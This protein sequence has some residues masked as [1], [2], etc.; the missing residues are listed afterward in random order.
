MVSTM[1][2]M[3][4]LS[5]A[6][7]ASS[8]SLDVDLCAKGESFWC[9]SLA[10]AEACSAVDHCKETIWR[11]QKL[12]KD[13]SDVCLFCKAV[14]SDA[15]KMSADGKTQDEVI[16]FLSAANDLLPD[17]DK[18]SQNK[19]TIKGKSIPKILDSEIEPQVV[20][21]LLDVCKGLQFIEDLHNLE[22]SPE[23]TPEQSIDDADNVLQ[24]TTCVDCTN[25][26][27]GLKKLITGQT[28][29]LLTDI[30]LDQ[31]CSRVPSYKQQCE[32][33][34]KKLLPDTIKALASFL[35]E[36]KVCRGMRMCPRPQIGNE[37][38]LLE[39]DFRSADWE[40]LASFLTKHPQPKLVDKFRQ[41]S[42]CTD[43]TNFFQS[44]KNLLQ[45]ETSKFI[46]DIILDQV[47]ARLGKHR[48]QCEGAVKSFLPTVIGMAV[49]FLNP[50][51][52][53][54]ATKMCK[55][56]QSEVD[57]NSISW[58]KL[59]LPNETNVLLQPNSC[60]DCTKF[61]ASV[62]DLIK[63]NA[64]GFIS[65]VMLDQICPLTLSFRKQCE[66]LVKT[67]LQVAL[68]LVV[69][70][71]DPA[72][73]CKTIGMCK[74]SEDEI[75]LDLFLIDL[76]SIDWETL[77]GNQGD[78][79]CDTCKTAVQFVQ[80]FVKSDTV[81]SSIAMIIGKFVCVR[82]GPFRVPCEKFVG[83][84]LRTI[85]DLAARLLD[86]SK[87]C[88]I[89][90]LCKNSDVVVSEE[91][92]DSV[93][94]LE[95]SEALGIVE[96]T[97]CETVIG[98]VRA[99]ID[100]NKT[101]GEILKAMHGLCTRMPSVSAVVCHR[102]VNNYGPRL[103][104]YIRRQL[105]PHDI[106]VKLGL[107]SV[108]DF[109]LLDVAA[110]MGS[111]SCIVCRSAVQYVEAFIDQ[112]DTV[113]NIQAQLK[114]LCHSLPP[115]VEKDICLPFVEKYIPPLIHEL[116]VLLPPKFFCTKIRICGD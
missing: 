45:N 13:E 99:A 87:V 93:P 110:V 105:Q 28:P 107:C 23:E 76:S 15:R 115:T 100:T 16:A 106:C 71:L 113:S 112:A 9:Q 2:L 1:Q 72:T 26:F 39:L 101:E 78:T 61:F 43:C 65:D 52:V 60:P 81:K 55:K 5:M 21:S 7:L 46:T 40:E 35:D 51:Q 95:D 8:A 108:F 3:V 27:S 64:S 4:L 69:S 54:Q 94:V 103:I 109:D 68:G 42:S 97:A 90:R 31:V 12:E 20:C 82:L 80:N 114:I 67:Y 91:K 37:E 58:T 29:A 59:I 70:T 102:F 116:S 17:T 66:D 6:V 32:D 84:E 10:V 92:E 89:I 63:N 73:V 88:R 104:D 14:V 47:C 41:P 86:P 11:N 85:L 56:S 77:I 50:T 38:N 34:A 25:F 22:S 18:A 75:E 30:V 36:N 62:R 111:E 48:A 49:Q 57:L 53:C 98:V 74:K 19:K 44:L 33:V 96:C 24:P 83:T 79:K